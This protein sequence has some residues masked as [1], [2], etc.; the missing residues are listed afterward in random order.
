MLDELKTRKVFP[1]YIP[2]REAPL[3]RS[4]NYEQFGLW[5]LSKTVIYIVRSLRKSGVV[6]DV[7]SR[8]GVLGDSKRLEEIGQ[9]VE[10]FESSWES[11]GST[12]DISALPSIE[13]FRHSVEDL[14]EELG[15]HRFSLLYDE[16]AHVLL[17]HQQRQFF[18]LF[19]SLRTPYISCVAAVYPGVTAYGQSFQPTHDASTLIVERDVFSSDYVDFMNDVVDQQ[20]KVARSSGSLKPEDETKLMRRKAE[21]GEHFAVL[22]YA[23]T[24]NPR[25]LLKTL[26]RVGKLRTSNMNSILRDYYR[27][28][29][30]FEHTDLG[31]RYEG[32]KPL[33]DWGREFIEEDVIHRIAE[34]NNEAL[35]S[36]GKTT[37]Y[38]WVQRDAPASVR[39]ALQLLMYTGV[40]SVDTE[41]YKAT[42][43]FIGTR[44]AVNLGAIFASTYSSGSPTQNAFSIA[45]GLSYKRLTTY[46]RDHDAFEPIKELNLP[47]ETE[48]EVELQKQL[49]RSLEVLDITDFQLESARAVG[50]D[51]I[52]KILEADTS[53]LRQ[54]DYIGPIRSRQIKNAAQTAAL[55]YLSG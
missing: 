46:S 6:S 35:E 45:K 28:D 37:R 34:K 30:W 19:R 13:S 40:I 47:P 51:T 48:I 17:P 2:L 29:L 9:I 55:E 42:H 31:D 44:Y 24:G 50:L 39:K 3:L 1:V 22:A 5:T 10:D 11:P 49:E 23:A 16:A 25:I 20:A 14:C 52:R 7:D 32:F 54:V 33:V 15:L 41:G 18:S 4:A 43:G 12:V 36:D 21:R 38:F 8:V 27:T 26:S 53:T